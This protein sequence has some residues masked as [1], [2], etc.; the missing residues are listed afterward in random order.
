MKLS[1]SGF[2][3][4]FSRIYHW[5]NNEIQTTLV[6]RFFF[7]KVSL[8]FP[9]RRSGKY[10]RLSAPL[11]VSLTSYPARF[12]S[13]HFTL[14]CLLSQSLSPDRVILWIANSDKEL[15]TFDILGLRSAG[16]EIEFCE[17][18]RSFKK[19]IPTL[20]QH[21]NCYIVT[22]DDDVYYG[23]TW[24]E[25]LV[26]VSLA[27]PKDVVC[28][29]SHTIRL[30]L[31]NLPLPYTEWDLDSHQFYASIFTF[32]TGV[33]G[34]LYP[35]GVF[36]SD[37]LN[38]VLFKE[39]CFDA[40]DVWLFWM[41]RMNKAIARRAESNFQWYSWPDTQKIA[42]WRSNVVEGNN[43]IQIRRMLEHY[44]SEIFRKADD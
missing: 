4:L 13:L 10:H 39:L 35:P 22:A 36:H 32:Q 17:D 38:I 15:L 14:K 28:H 12:P 27:N 5:V 43:D 20:E 1:F 37:V 29:R 26:K 7:L 30:G 33:G 21:G 3:H 25:E 6:P 41:M 24:L 8:C 9:F 16:L 11:I 42:L 34:V 2:K 31:D 19:I 23:P 44:G 18:L 40:D